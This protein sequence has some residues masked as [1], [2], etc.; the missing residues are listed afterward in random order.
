MRLEFEPVGVHVLQ[1]TAWF[2]PY[3][4]GGTEVYLDELT[5]ALRQ[6]GTSSTI[7]VPRHRR[8]PEHYVHAQTPVLTYPVNEMPG[9]DELQRGAPHAEF[10]RF[11]S[12]LDEHAGAIYHQHAWTRGC[13]A[14][15]LHA[16]RRRNFR[17]VLTIHV[18]GNFCLRGSMLRFGTVPCDGKVDDRACAACWTERQ[19]LSQ[20][21]AKLM[22]NLPI[23]L[24]KAARRAP[25]GRLATAIGARELAAQKLD[26]VKDMAVAADRIVVVCEWVRDALLEMGVAR[27]KLVLSRQGLASSY[28]EKAHAAVRETPTH[29]GALRLLFLGRW[30]HAK[31]IDIAV[32]SV[33]ELPPTANVRLTVHASKSVSDDGAYEASVRA[34]A[35][36]DSR[37]VFAPAVPRADLAAVMAAHDVLLVPSR[38]METGPLVVLEAQAA[39]LFVVGSRL[40]GIVE[41]VAEGDH[42]SLPPAHD[43]KAW[44]AAIEHLAARHAG[45]RLARS[46]RIVRTMDAVAVEMNQLYR[47][48][49]A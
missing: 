11:L 38:T 39:G 41:L 40:G 27:S 23:S 8:A 21:A 37:I 2:P 29:S 49:A 24:A 42:G 4:M 28:M 12:L 47:T 45:N 46:P 14:N 19:G 15:H 1:S 22:A 16:A 43:T 30:D 6:L 31:G 7:I 26:A 9:R 17:T 36:G 25:A 33:R 5:Q 20:P 34:M 44:T 18:A 32:R 13:G 3:D 48:L 10:D 35:A